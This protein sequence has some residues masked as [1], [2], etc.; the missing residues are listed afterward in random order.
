MRR[1]F[2]ERFPRHCWLAI[3]TSITACVTPVPWCMPGSLTGGL[4]WNQWRGKCSRHSRR[5][6]N[7]LLCVSGKRPMA[8]DSYRGVD[9]APILVFLLHIWDDAYFQCHWQ[10]FTK[11][12]W[13]HSSNLLCYTFNSSRPSDAYMR[14]WHRPSLDQ[15]VTWRLFDAEPYRWYSSIRTIYVNKLGS[16]VTALG[17][18]RIAHYL[19]WHIFSKLVNY[20]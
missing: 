1:E 19:G 12:Y 6:R 20:K 3:A 10:F 18:S 14:Q 13:S 7:P 16:H 4:F 2:R 11:K 15:I 8:N 5:M 17:K 9:V